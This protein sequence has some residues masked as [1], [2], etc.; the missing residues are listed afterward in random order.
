ML[1]V[2][3]AEPEKNFVERR[4]KMKRF[5]NLPPV[6]TL[7]Y[8][9]IYLPWFMALEARDPSECTIVQLH[10]DRM[11]PFCE[12]FVIPYLLW[13]F[14]IGAVVTYLILNRP[15]GEY[16]RFAAL[17]FGGFTVCLI[18]Y[19]FFY[20]GLDLRPAIDPGKNIFTWMTSRVWAADTSTNVC[21][22]I[23]VYA[24][25]AAQSLHHPLYYVPQ[26]ALRSGRALRL[27]TLRRDTSGSP[28][29]AGPRTPAEPPCPSS[30]LNHMPPM[31]PSR[32]GGI[33]VCILNDG[34]IRC[35]QSARGKNCSSPAGPL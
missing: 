25:L 8:F 9:A 23:H 31:R 22:S 11:I 32:I 5:A 18:L 24:T 15:K 6:W 13:F 10:V 33:F 2:S 27:R 28:R 35:H 19:S 1:S 20:T 17:L 34:I 4:D 30:H 29:R 14:Y 21:P 3:G 26:T 7:S 12:Y 16:Y